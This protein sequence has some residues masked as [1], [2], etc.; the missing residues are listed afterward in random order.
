[1]GHCEKLKYSRKQDEDTWNLHGCSCMSTYLS[2]DF[3]GSSD[4]CQ[5]TLAHGTFPASLALDCGGLTLTDGGTL[6]DG[7]TNVCN[8]TTLHS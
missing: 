5:C 3:S 2:I 6:Q 4:S 8:K 1:M 7:G